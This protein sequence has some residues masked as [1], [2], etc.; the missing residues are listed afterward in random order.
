MGPFSRG[1]YEWVTPLYTKGV[2]KVSHI[3]KIRF[4]QTFK[5][6]SELGNSSE[7]LRN[8]GHLRTDQCKYFMKDRQQWRL[9]T[10]LFPPPIPPTPPEF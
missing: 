2:Q 8:C 1:K 4:V 7:C 3:S 10:H 9:T 5:V 6:L